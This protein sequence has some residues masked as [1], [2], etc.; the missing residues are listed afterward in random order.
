MKTFDPMLSVDEAFA[1][2]DWGATPVGP[3]TG[4]PQSLRTALSI[5]RESRFPFIIF[6][7]PELVQFYN[8]AYRPILGEKH[9]RAMGQPAREC[10]PEI[11][12]S[13][14]PML[15]GVLERGEATWSE[16][17]LLRIIRDGSPGEYYFTFSYSPIRDEHGIGGVFCA[18]HETTERVLRSR[19]L[20]ELNRAKTTF[21]NNITHEFRTPLALLTG[22]LDDALKRSTDPIVRESI[23]SAQRNALRLLKLVNSLL[24]FARIE[25]GRMEPSFTRTDIVAF[26]AA[27]TA[28]FESLVRRAG[29]E[30]RFETTGACVAHV[31]REMWEHI[32]FNLLSNAVK[33]TERGFIAV[34][35]CCEPERY[36]LIVRD[37]G[38]G[39]PLEDRERIFERFHRVQSARGRSAEGA[40][41]GLA[42][43][44]ELVELHN[45]SIEVQSDAGGSRFIV[46]MPSAGALSDR[47]AT[48]SD[49]RP[50]VTA[51]SFLAEAEGW[52][53]A[54]DVPAI[55]PSTGARV[56]IVDDNA[57]VRAYLRRLLAADYQVQTAANGV[58]ALS[59]LA[60]EPVDLVV[61][62]VM[63]PAMDGHELLARIRALPNGNDVA[64]I[65]L[66]ARGAEN[67]IATA[68]GAGGDDYL[69]KPFAG[70]ELRARVAT[71]LRLQRARRNAETAEREHAIVFE[72]LTDLLPGMV[73]MS[74]ANGDRAFN[75]SAWR[76]YT[77]SEPGE[78]WSEK[79]HP[80]DRPLWDEAFATARA[81]GQ[82]F[83][84]DY[85]LWNA[86]SARYR[87]VTVHAFE[88]TVAG[89]AKW[90]GTILDIDDRKR[91][92]LA[93][94]FL[95]DASTV[96][97]QTLN[98][99][100]TLSRLATLV[101]SS[102]CDYCV[103]YI[104]HDNEIRRAVWLHRD[105]EQQANLDEIVEHGPDPNDPEWLVARVMRENRP[106]LWQ[107]G[108]AMADSFQQEPRYAELVTALELQSVLIVP[109]HI[110]ASVYGALA[111]ARAGA[112]TPFD[113]F[114]VDI[115]MQ[116]A[117]RAALA[118]ANAD[119]FEREH[120][121]ALSFQNA[122]LPDRLPQRAG[123]KVDAFY[124]AGRS[125][126]RVGGDWYDVELLSDGRVLLS[127]GD[128]SGSGLDA[129]VVMSMV[130]NAMRSVAHVYADPATILEAAQR[131]T[132]HRLGE[133][134]VTAFVAVVDPVLG[135]LTYCNAGHMP[136]L[137]RQGSEVLSVMS[138]GFP[139]GL[140]L[141]R[142]WRTEMM[143]IAGESSF[144]LYTD[145][146]TEG[147]GAFLPG[148]DALI[149]EV[150]SDRFTQFTSA[151]ELYEALLPNGSR[152]DVA[153]LI[154]HVSATAVD[155][156][157][158]RIPLSIRESRDATIARDAICARLFETRVFSK[159]AAENARLTIGELTANVARH[160]PGDAFAIID[161][162]APAPVF[163]LVD[164]GNGFRYSNRLPPN[165]FA[166]SGR[167]L[168]IASALSQRIEVLPD[169][170]GGSHVIVVLRMN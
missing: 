128:V 10:W 78:H 141:E 75:N 7:G 82:P 41:I 136:P 156:Q 25:A 164:N 93:N 107:R 46:S 12:D 151:H 29:L 63:M 69:A 133:H 114:D 87:W 60:R 14:G 163:H 116:L 144:V 44:K 38:I 140:G 64:V 68:L 6:W 94:A 105:A 74:D 47:D 118:V 138:E 153:I 135:R 117:N 45:G 142:E 111:L 18:V 148:E 34:T 42:L 170:D 139:I 61:T 21:F 161:T 39:V 97:S 70:S 65:L 127:I 130:R 132:E 71:Q 169:I 126:A 101:V 59:I 4:W 137:I 157:T 23:A 81:N 27:L 31:D 32:V 154:A 98:L 19:Q 52:L 112:T 155:A 125:E 89:E 165:I 149:A 108:Q 115:V 11:W 30:W 54:S 129:A 121:V 22:P 28:P 76:T 72:A 66:S 167:G 104:L 26:T 35:L 123:V 73:W 159:E 150:A 162:A 55:A 57:D 2:V 120:R 8:E 158:V 88:T 79:S 102:M 58:A 166:E 5:C 49:D 160:A 1:D 134:F 90:V 86:S 85:R 33:Y 119:L 53:E 100:Q 83:T 67:E 80:Q 51:Q 37:T 152:D 48:E 3:P 99:D 56:L 103:F 92:E 145:G 143:R 124:V 50:I 96:L 15:H 146:L 110:G 36:T 84:L 13:V 95:A 109:V 24:A 106:N 40:G 113:D 43:V 91:R 20:L 62:D 147:A 17:L 168:F 16:D 9:P 77:G 122:A 131:A